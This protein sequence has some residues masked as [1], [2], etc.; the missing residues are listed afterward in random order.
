[1]ALQTILGGS[2]YKRD[3]GSRQTA[4][5]TELHNTDLDILNNKSKALPMHM[6]V[7]S[8]AENESVNDIS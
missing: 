1:M 5:N 3:P 6:V 8:T 4:Q 7:T 2:D